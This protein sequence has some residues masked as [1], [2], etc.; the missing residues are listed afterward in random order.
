MS[1]VTWPWYMNW[2]GSCWHQSLY[3]PV[4][5]CPCSLYDRVLRLFLTASN[6]LDFKGKVGM[7]T[8]GS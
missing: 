7:W 2:S 3:V 8:T 5:P 1:L 4:Q 6:S